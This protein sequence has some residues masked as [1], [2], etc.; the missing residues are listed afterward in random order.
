MIKNILKFGNV[1]GS[2]DSGSY[3]KITTSFFGKESQALNIMPYGMWG[4][5]PDGSLAV[6]FNIGGMESNQAAIVNDYKNRPVKDMEKGEV[7]FG[8]GIAGTYLKFNTDGS[9]SLQTSEGLNLEGD[10]NVNGDINSTGDIESDG[11]ITGSDLT[12]GI[13]VYSTHVHGGVTTGGSATLVPQ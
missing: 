8:N 13:T 12:D 10:L 7:A 3:P 9:V 1:T 5:A 6:V 11:L 4:R 2:D